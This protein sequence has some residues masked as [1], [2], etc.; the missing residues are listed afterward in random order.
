MTDFDIGFPEIHFHDTKSTE[1]SKEFLNKT[2]KVER[3]KE[4]W[5]KPK[6]SAESQPPL[7]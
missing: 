3:S 7:A 2:N 1:H 6:F 5:H 4:K